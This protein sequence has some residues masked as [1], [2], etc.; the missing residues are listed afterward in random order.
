MFLVSLLLSS[1]AVCLGEVQGGLP[2]VEVYL[3][4]GAGALHG[5]AAVAV[6]EEVGLP[7]AGLGVPEDTIIEVFVKKR[8]KF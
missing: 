8:Q 2:G 7:R 1:R 4:G 3:G 6:G 5:Q